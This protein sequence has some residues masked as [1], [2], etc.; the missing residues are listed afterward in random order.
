MKFQLIY[1]Q[2]LK[3][4]QEPKKLLKMGLNFKPPVRKLSRMVRKRRAS[5][6]PLPE[7]T[8][9]KC[10]Y[11]RRHGLYFEAYDFGR[12][13]SIVC[14]S[15]KLNKFDISLKFSSSKVFSEAKK[16]LV[17]DGK[18]REAIQFASLKTNTKLNSSYIYSVRD[19]RLTIAFFIAKL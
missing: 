13:K 1:P 10:N 11:H 4:R 5:L 18:F 14:E 15:V 16:Q 2:F 6:A 7:C 19:D 3:E 12:V 8:A 9:T 17:D